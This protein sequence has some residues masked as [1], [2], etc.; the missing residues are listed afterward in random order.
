LG[1]AYREVGKLPEAIGLLEHALDRA[2]LRPGGVT[3]RLA[4][5]H[6]ALAAAYEAAAQSDMEEK[7][8]AAAEVRLRDC[9]KLRRQVQ[10]DAWTPFRAQSLLGGSLLGQK[11]LAEAEPLLLQGYE[12]MHER[13][14]QI[15]VGAKN[16]LV[17]AAQRL[18]DLYVAWDRP[19]QAVTWRKTVAAE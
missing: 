13:A 15:P 4:G 12:G 10:R 1:D 6:V 5:I 18:V 7:K 2:R 8:Y 16:R 9:L 3:A 11:N 17:E 14:S 19:D